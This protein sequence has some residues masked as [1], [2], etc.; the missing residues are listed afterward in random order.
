MTGV[1][2]AALASPNNSV[3]KTIHHGGLNGF[4]I[5]TAS[6]SYFSNDVAAGLNVLS[7][8]DSS[9]L[10]SAKERGLRGRRTGDQAPPSRSVCDASSRVR[11]HIHI[12]V[13][14]PDSHN[15][16]QFTVGTVTPGS[17]VAFASPPSTRSARAIQA[18]SPSR[19]MASTLSES[20]ERHDEH[21]RWRVIPTS[22][23]QRMTLASSL[24]WLAT[25]RRR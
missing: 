25:T 4:P 11:D 14:P 16:G 20:P 7:S 6:T 8:S 2:D 19:V 13:L 5:S 22:G 3:Y 21:Q 18:I 12:R 24:R 1:T 15:S 10:L 9:F 23:S 17:T